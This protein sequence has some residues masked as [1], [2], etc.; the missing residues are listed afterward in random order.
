MPTKYANVATNTK[1]PAIKNTVFR[2]FEA[3]SEYIVVSPDYRG[4]LLQRDIF[5]WK[6]STAH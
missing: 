6:T 5:E 4:K 3:I 2:L 1:N